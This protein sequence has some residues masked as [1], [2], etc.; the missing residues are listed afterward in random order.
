MMKKWMIGSVASFLILSSLA[1]WGYGDRQEAADEAVPVNASTAPQHAKQFKMIDMYNSQ[2]QK[3]GHARLSE[4]AKGLKIQLKVS[5]LSPGVHGYHIHETGKCIAP[6]FKS[7]G[8]HFN[9][10]SKEHGFHNP[11][12]YHAGDLPNLKVDKDGMVALTTYTKHATLVKGKPHSLLDRDGSA[13]VIHE[14]ADDYKTNPAGNA[15]ARV[16]CGV[17]K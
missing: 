7:A 12:G 9:P 2:K 13:L 6:D 1:I 8:D 17:I 11:K 16:A 3:I 5:N 14:K 15:G 4:T 10:A